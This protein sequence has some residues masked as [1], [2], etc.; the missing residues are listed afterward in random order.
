MQDLSLKGNPEMML[1]K[2]EYKLNKNDEIEY[3]WHLKSIN[4]VPTH[5]HDGS[6]FGFKSMAVYIPSDDIYML[7]FSNCDCN[8]PTQLVKDIAKLTLENAKTK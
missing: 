7:E 3:G 8:S 2:I 4:G 5:Q 1:K 6:I